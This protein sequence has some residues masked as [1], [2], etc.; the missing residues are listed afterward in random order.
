MKLN[1]LAIEIIKPPRLRP[2]YHKRND[3]TVILPNG[4][5]VPDSAV[6][7][8]GQRGTYTVDGF[9]KLI[10]NNELP[11]GTILNVYINSKTLYQHELQNIQIS[12]KVINR[13]HPWQAYLYEMSPEFIEQAERCGNG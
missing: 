12:I 1:Q 9:I 7:E 11:E 13:Y 6:M 3:E 10:D 8:F 2:V 4:L 5:P